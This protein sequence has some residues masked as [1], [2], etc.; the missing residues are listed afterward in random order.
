VQR[1]AAVNRVEEKL[2]VPVRY[3]IANPSSYLYLEP[4]R[5]VSD[6]ANGCPGYNKYKYGLVELSG[7]ARTTGSGAIRRT[8][9]KRK[10]TYLLGELDTKDSNDLDKTCPA[11]AQ[12]ENRMQRGVAYHKRFNETFNA[13]HNLVIVPGCGHS[14]DCMFRTEAAKKVLFAAIQSTP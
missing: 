14:A 10:V 2:S 6:P 7:Y 4:W 1:Y 8:Y 9:P 12:G 5:P 11:M 3:M 13:S